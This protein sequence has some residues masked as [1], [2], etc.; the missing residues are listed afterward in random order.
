M[1]HHH[2]IIGLGFLGHCQRE[3][4]VCLLFGGVG[5]WGG[6]RVGGMIDCD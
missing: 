5:G 2:V 1:H 6:G 4:G 3:G